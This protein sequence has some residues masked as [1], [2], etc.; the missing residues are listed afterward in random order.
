MTR[1]AARRASAVQVEKSLPPAPS[2]S[3]ETDA[4]PASPPSAMGVPWYW[5]LALFLWATS[6]AFLFLYEWLAGLIKAW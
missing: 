6:F 2:S 1:S 5:R 4:S 3:D